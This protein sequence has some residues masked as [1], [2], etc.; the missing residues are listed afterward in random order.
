MSEFRHEYKYVC[1]LDKMEYI[2]CSVSA[3]MKLD[4]HAKK[5]GEYSVRS[6]YFDDYKETFYYDNMYGV[7]PREKFRI[8]IYNA[9]A[10]KITLELK[11]KQ[12]GKTRKLSCPLTKE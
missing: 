4:N 9:D 11:Q 6:V 3:L 12:R 8:R 1:S 7:D 2:K 5:Q 10:S